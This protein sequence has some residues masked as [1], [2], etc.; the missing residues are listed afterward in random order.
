MEV[1]PKNFPRISMTDKIYPV[2]I[3]KERLEIVNI[4]I[5]DHVH[6][7]TL[8]IKTARDLKSKIIYEDI[9]FRFEKGPDFVINRLYKGVAI[10]DRRRNLKTLQTARIICH[11]V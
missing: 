3:W 6:R 5:Y 8:T 4:A 7:K 2:Y 10:F 9:E 11:H 1:I